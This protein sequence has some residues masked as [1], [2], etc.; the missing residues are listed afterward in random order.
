MKQDGNFSR[1]AAASELLMA[2]SK[3]IDATAVL[4]QLQKFLLERMF[5]STVLTFGSGVSSPPPLLAVAICRT[6][7]VGS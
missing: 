4:I 5:E 2:H 1:W 7:V 3:F 6:F